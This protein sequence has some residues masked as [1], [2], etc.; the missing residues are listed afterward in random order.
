[1][2]E[3]FRRLLIVAL[4][5]TL[6][7]RLTDYL[8]AK[9]LGAGFALLLSLVAS[10]FLAHVLEFLFLDLP[11]QFAFLRRL[12]DPIF[13]IEGYWYERVGSEDHPHSYVCIEYDPHSKCFR[14][15]GQNFTSDF[16]LN[17]SFV[18]ERAQVHRDVKQ[19]SFTFL[20]DIHRPA[21]STLRGYGTINFFGD[22]K[23]SFTRAY[24]SFVESHLQLDA[25]AA[26]AVR[27]EL[28]MRELSLQLDK[29]KDGLVKRATGRRRIRSNEDIVKLLKR[30]RPDNEAGVPSQAG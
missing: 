16:Q 18:S 24:G 22:G 8:V 28:P 3:R 23:R 27:T 13:T 1:M 14:Y 5:A 29:I 30:L 7:V 21:R 6:A 4:G 10:V 20:A 25:A 19:I 17:A 11:M 12:L 15:S 26:A 2:S 9:N